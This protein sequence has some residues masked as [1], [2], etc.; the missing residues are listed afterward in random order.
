MGQKVND[1]QNW[2]EKNRQELKIKID[3][4]GFDFDIPGTQKL[5]K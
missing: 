4:P 3:H 1:C 2:F 5:V